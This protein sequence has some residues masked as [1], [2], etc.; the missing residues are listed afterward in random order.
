MVKT[1]TELIKKYKVKLPK[2][3]LRTTPQEK[4]FKRK[5]GA[6]ETLIV[7]LRHD[8]TC[9]NGHNSFSITGSYYYNDEWRA[10]GCLHKMIAE[11]FPELQ[12]L[13]KWHNTTTDG[14][15]YYIENS[16][17]FAEQGQLKEARAAAVWP[18]ASLDDI[19]DDEKMARHLEEIMPQFRA[20]IEA[21]GFKY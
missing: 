19:M 6:H 18:T 16:R 14:P 21:I 11:H 9:R 1:T 15:L 12:Y 7:N 3:Q 2:S 4:E 17:Y 10:G 5:I 20:D 8:D 13:I